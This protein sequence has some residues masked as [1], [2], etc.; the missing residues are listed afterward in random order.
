MPAAADG[1]DIQI[2]SERFQSSALAQANDLPCALT[3]LVAGMHL[4]HVPHRLRLRQRCDTPV[5]GQHDPGHIA[6][7]RV[8][9]SCASL[10]RHV[11]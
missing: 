5:V 10:L 1:I 7:S 9:A 8:T 6:S 2:V 11:D 3:R 4:S